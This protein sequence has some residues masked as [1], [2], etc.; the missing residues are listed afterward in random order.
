MDSFHGSLRICV[1]G[2]SMSLCVG[3]APLPQPAC[4]QAQLAEPACV[5]TLAFAQCGPQYVWPAGTSHVQPLCAQ[6]WGP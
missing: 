3:A 6:G 2:F 4:P 5:S 1:Q